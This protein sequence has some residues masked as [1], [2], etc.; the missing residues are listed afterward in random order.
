MKIGVNLL[1]FTQDRF[2]GVEQYLKN[3][4]LNLILIDPQLQLFLFTPTSFS[5]IFPNHRKIKRVFI[6]DSSNHS[7]VIEAIR[8]YNLDI[9]FCPVHRSYLPNISIPTVVTIHDVLHAFYPDFVP[10]GKEENNRYYQQF[11]P[12]FEAVLTVSKFSK[13]SITEQLLIPREKVHA[14]YSDASP[15]FSSPP[16]RR[17]MAIIKEKYQLPQSFALYPASYNPHKNHQNLLKALV[18]LRENYNLT[19]PLVLTGY[20]YQSN[21]IYQSILKFL[22]DYS[23]RNQVKIV[24]YVPSEEMPYLYHLARLLIFPSLFEGFGIPL[25]EAM[26]TQ[27]PIVCSN[28]ASIPEVVGEAALQFN[29]HS[30]QEIASAI[31]QIAHPQVRFKLIQKGKER[32]KLFSWKRCAM[33]TLQV[34]YGIC[35]KR[36]N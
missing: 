33:E 30:P 4:M 28:Q 6:R 12:S 3:L 21:M 34:F 31:L 14:I 10:G 9:W 22:E 36:H 1:N 24:G 26:K 27:T 15:E 23:L 13:K 18:F 11:A 17:Q 29:P 25:V 20:T 16:D 32:A 5:D 35:H 7:Q 19:V 8:R 2:G